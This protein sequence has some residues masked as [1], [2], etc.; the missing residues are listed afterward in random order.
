VAALALASA[1]R[2][3]AAWRQHVAVADRRIR[4]RGRAG[5]REEKAATLGDSIAPC[6][7]NLVKNGGTA[8][9]A[10]IALSLRLRHLH[11]SGLR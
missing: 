9:P 8:P 1:G 7:E 11:M 4:Q 10:S 2:I 5:H 6:C 3:A